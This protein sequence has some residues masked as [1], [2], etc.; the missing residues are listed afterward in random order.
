MDKRRGLPVQKRKITAGAAGI[1]IGLG[2]QPIIS[3]KN[4]CSYRSKALLGRNRQSV[5]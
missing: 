5:C 3:F 4:Y 2:C 1:Y